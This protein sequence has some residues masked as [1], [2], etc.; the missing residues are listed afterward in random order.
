[1]AFKDDEER[2]EN[3]LGAARAPDR[4]ELRI[5]AE[6]VEQRLREGEA[7]QNGEVRA[8]PEGDVQQARLGRTNEKR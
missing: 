4:E 3:D 8:V 7:R 1:M 2:K 5:A 6:N